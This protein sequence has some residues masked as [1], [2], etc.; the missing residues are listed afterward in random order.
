MNAPVLF[1]RS[2]HVDP[3]VDPMSR[4]SERGNFRRHA[5]EGALRLVW[6]WDLTAADI[7]GARGIITTMHLDQIRMMEF[8]AAFEAFLD[9]GGRLVFN[10]HVTRPFITGLQPFVPVGGGR[11]TD[12]ELTPLAEHPIFAGVDRDALQLSRGVAGFY[13]RGCNPMPDGA[14]ALTGVGPDKLP[15]DWRWLRPGGGAI[16]SHAGNDW[17]SAS[18]A[19]PAVS[20]LADNMMAW[21]AHEVPA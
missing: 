11:R 17:W 14:L 20:Q 2:H 6:E 21:T 19:K 12:F 15:V 10:G 9:R 13:G 16:L 5:D 7:A 18:A 8:S 1:I 4:G 3:A